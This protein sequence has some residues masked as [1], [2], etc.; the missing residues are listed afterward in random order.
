MD[1]SDGIQYAID[2]TKGNI[3]VCKD[4]QL[5]CQR[6]LD[7]MANRHWEYEFVSDYVDHFISFARVLKHTK[8][9]DA[10]TPIKMEPFQVFAIC[11]IYGFR[12]KKDHTKRMT[13]DV[14]IFIPR[15]AGKSTFTAMISLYELRYGPKID[16]FG[17]II[18]AT[19]TCLLKLLLCIHRKVYLILYNPYSK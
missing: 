11:A 17:F 12:A 4:V 18:I 1:Y 15:K 7:M 3:E 10:G 5:V 9:P 6:F 16:S 13:T 19:A 8:G 14:I 2:V